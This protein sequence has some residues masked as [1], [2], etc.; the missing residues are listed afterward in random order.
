M[1]VNDFALLGVLGLAYWYDLR[2]RR[3]PNRLLLLA[4]GWGLGYHISLSGANGIFFSLKGLGIGLLLLLLPFAMGGMG[5][6]DVKFLGVIGAIKG[7]A[8][9][10]SS[11]LW[12]ALWGGVIAFAYL[13]YEGRLKESVGNVARGLYLVQLGVVKLSASVDKTEFHVFFPYGIPIALGAITELCMV[14]W[15]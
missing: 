11:F 3:I 10:L 2:E 13:L 4:L 14:W 8:F 9:I 12:M 1:L 5:A 6:G 7:T 15:L